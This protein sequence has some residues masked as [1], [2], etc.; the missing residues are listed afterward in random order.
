MTTPPS[1]SRRQPAAEVS[2][3]KRRWPV[4][5]GPPLLFVAALA[6]VIGLAGPPAK[7][8]GALSI[9]RL[10]ACSP[11]H[12]AGSGKSVA[13]WKTID[14]TD[15]TGGLTGHQLFLGAGAQSS[16]DAPLPIES[17]VSGPVGGLVA[18]TMDDGVRSVLQLADVEGRC[19]ITIDRRA[20]VIRNAIIDPTDGSVFAHLVARDTR[21]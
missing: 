8:G 13:W 20:D 17:S 21:A 5:L 6:A 11:G 10:A 16:A 4:L 14:R 19:S 1:S 9:A 18:V 12:Q 2:M 15:A 7:A 3:S